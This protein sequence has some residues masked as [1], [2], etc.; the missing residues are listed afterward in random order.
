[1]S[2]L[3]GSSPTPSVSSG[4]SSNV[5]RDYIRN[6]Y[7]GQALYGT[8]SNNFLTSLLTNTGDMGEAQQGFNNYK[9]VGGY[10]AAMNELAKKTTGQ[11]AAAGALGSGSFRKALQDRGTN[12]NNQYFTNYLQQLKDLSGLGLQAGGL[13][14]NTGQVSSQTGTGGTAGQPGLLGSIIGGAASI[15]GK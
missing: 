9:S 11:M 6:Q 10:E 3:F 1:M 8:R 13:I 2:F 7:E 14:A 5:N 12:L 4:N 15:F